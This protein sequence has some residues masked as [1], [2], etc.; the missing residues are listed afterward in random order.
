MTKEGIDDELGVEEN[1]ISIQTLIGN[2]VRIILKIIGIV[3]KKPLIMLIDNGST[4]SFLDCST[5]R[6]LNCDLQR[7]M[8]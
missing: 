1:N 4:L 3:K 2:K 8:P 6:E 5:T 7:T